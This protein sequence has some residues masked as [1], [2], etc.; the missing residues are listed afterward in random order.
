MQFHSFQID[1][2]YLVRFLAQFQNIF[3]SP[4]LDIL[5]EDLETSSKASD[6]LKKQEGTFHELAG[7][8][9]FTFDRRNRSFRCCR[10]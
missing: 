10:S 8:Y 6:T 7:D 1:A 5:F 2:P 3:L 4:E 9:G